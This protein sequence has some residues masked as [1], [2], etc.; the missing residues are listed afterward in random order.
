MITETNAS[1]L[2]NANWGIEHAC[3]ALKIPKLICARN[4]ISPNLDD[5]SMIVYLSYFVDST[6]QEEIK[7]SP[8]NLNIDEF[9]LGFEKRVSMGLIPTPIDV[10]LDRFNERHY[11]DAR[12]P[13]IP[14]THQYRDIANP[15]S[16]PIPLITKT[17]P[18]LPLKDICWD[19]TTEMQSSIGIKFSPDGIIA[20]LSSEKVI[21]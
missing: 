15:P 3:I 14:I 20:S 2:R 18:S 9:T 13:V 16:S 1:C 4:I 19:M 17:L 5:Q 10:I 11:P 7:N 8:A 12:H 6:R 21:F